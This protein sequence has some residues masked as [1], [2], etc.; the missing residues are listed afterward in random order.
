MSQIGK[1]QTWSISTNKFKKWTR[2]HPEISL[3]V[4]KDCVINCLYFLEVIKNKEI[5]NILSKYSNHFGGL[6]VDDILKIVFDTMNENNHKNGF[7]I[8]HTISE[9]IPL[10]Q[11]DK[12][13]ELKN[14]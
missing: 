3:D 1:I 9:P 12:I 5:A 8:N 2:L 10:S 14:N 4:A 6:R 11:N 13:N 7:K